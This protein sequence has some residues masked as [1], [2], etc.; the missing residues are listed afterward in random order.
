LPD[1]ALATL[2]TVWKQ[3]KEARVFRRAH[4]VRAI[5]KG[6]RLPTAS[7]TRAFTSAALSTWVPRCAQEGA[8]GLVARPRSGRPPNVTCALAMPLKRLVEP[9]PR[10]HGARAAQ[11]SGRALATGLAHQTGIQLGRARVRR[12]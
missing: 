3:T 7:D 5:V 4:A 1:D 6:P 8:Q 2:D 9:A 10:H 11:G 12:V